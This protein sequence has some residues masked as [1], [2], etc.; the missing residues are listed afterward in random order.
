[1]NH[2]PWNRFRQLLRQLGAAAAALYCA[3]AVLRRLPG[4]SG[5]VY[6]RFLSQP[7]HDKPRVPQG[8]GQQ[9]GFRWLQGMEPVLT[10]LDRPAPVLAARFAQGA[11]CLLATREQALVGCIWYVRRVYR[12]D[13][14]RVDYVLPP[15]GDCV[16]DF[17][18]FVA[19]VERLGYLF[20]RQWDVFDADLRA[21]GMRYSISR[22]NAFNQRSV[23]SHRALGARDC[24]WAVFVCLGAAQLML[25]AQVPYV[26]LGGRPRLQIHPAAHS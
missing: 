12:E 9:F 1:M 11:Q 8:R 16:W 6:Y 15:T 18:V 20:A 2:T 19:P 4:R 22:I 10:A 5:L 21:Q 26:A 14:V 25:S 17:D 23:A 7:L 3:D 13:E 24:G